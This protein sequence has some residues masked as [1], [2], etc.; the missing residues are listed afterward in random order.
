[1][2]M[3]NHTRVRCDEGIEVVNWIWNFSDMGLN[4]YES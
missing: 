3:V 4:P 1:M 2:M